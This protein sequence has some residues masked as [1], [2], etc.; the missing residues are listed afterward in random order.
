MERK[1]ILNKSVILI[2]KPAGI[3]SF[4]A[5]EIVSKILNVKKA[6]HSGTLDPNAT[7]LLV[8]A[9]GEA[10]KAMPVLSGL[11][12][13]Y[14]GTMKL[15][16]DTEENELKKALKS[17]LGEITQIPPV[18]SA[19]ARKPRKRHVYEIDLL[20]MRGKD[21]RFR[22][23]CE[24]GTYIR[25][26]A[27][28]TGEN[29][30][31]GAHL[32]ELRRTSVG[33]FGIEDA[34]AIPELKKMTEIEVNKILITLEKALEMIRLPKIVIKNEYEPKIRNG[35]PVRKDFVLS[36]PKGAKENE[37]AGV[38]NEMGGIVCLAKYIDKEGTIA[39][40]ERVFLD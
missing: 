6:G 18:K 7:G 4:D 37:Y 28:D 25:K 31:C 34:I 38:F 8:I 15:H 2:D 19:V 22:V 17:F 36:A 30:G 29:L 13:E 9:L 5:V 27:H 33:P 35:S 26:I 20:E 12:K 39:K 1:S 3:T 32:I 10:R 23:K 11:D 21:V 14:I 24:A 40:T 16:G